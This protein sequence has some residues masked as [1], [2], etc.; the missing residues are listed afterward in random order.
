MCIKG[1]EYHYIHLCT[2]A[3]KTQPYSVN[4]IKNNKK[5]KMRYLLPLGAVLQD[6]WSIINRP[7]VFAYGEV[8]AFMLVHLY[9]QIVVLQ[10]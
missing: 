7:V 2:Y 5:I 1:I 4:F 10:L 3:D 9:H 8:R 6:A